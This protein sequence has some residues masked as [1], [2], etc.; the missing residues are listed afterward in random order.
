MMELIEE[1]NPEFPTSRD[2]EKAINQLFELHRT[3][4]NK[5]LEDAGLDYDKNL[6][7]WK[8]LYPYNRAEYRS[9]Q[10]RYLPDEEARNSLG[11]L[12]C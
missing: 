6:D 5:L 2:I 7:P 12:W 1:K 11:K 4:F 3:E 8:G 10:G 9:T